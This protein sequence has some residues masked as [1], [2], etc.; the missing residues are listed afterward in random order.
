MNKIFLIFVWFC[1][2]L[3]EDCEDIEYSYEQFHSG[4]Y[5]VCELN[6]DC[7]AVWGHCDVGLGGCHYA[8]N[9]QSYPI[10]SINEL[11]G[12]WLEE[13]C[14]EWVCDCSALPNVQCENG[15]CQLEYCY[16]TNP[17]GCFNAGCPEG[18][19]CVD[20]PDYCV[21]SSCFCDGFY[22]EWFCTEDCGGGTCIEIVPPDDNLGDINF[23]GILNVLDIV[24]MVNLILSNE[25]ILIAD[26]N[27][28]GF[29]DVLDVVMMANILIGGLP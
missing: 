15:Q 23:D 20:H 14:M 26:V 7:V 21:P 16:E 1:F 3:G 4:N 6:Q 29:V 11:V 5:S 2:V 17:E 10:D 24:L 9:E 25:Y 19:E 8:V 22:S 27:E 12:A 28:D 18:Y 13:D